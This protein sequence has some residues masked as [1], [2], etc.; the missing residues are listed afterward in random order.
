VKS[1]HW[2]LY[3][4]DPR[5]TAEGLN[6]MQLDS[7]SLK[8]PLKEYHEKENRFR[9]LMKSSPEASQRYLKQAQETV[10]RRFEHFKQLADS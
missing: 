5:R 2:L 7:K 9:M 10:N 3:R 4:Y 8:I 6:P 1:G